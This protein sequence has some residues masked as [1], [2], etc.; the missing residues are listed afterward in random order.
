MAP[1]LLEQ[2]AVHALQQR[3]WADAHALAIRLIEQSGLEPSGHF[4]AGVAALESKK[5][6]EAQAHLEQA[7]ALA[8]HRPDI[9][10][11]LARAR[12]SSQHY[13]SALEAA[14]QAAA[15]LSQGSPG[16]FDTLGVVLVQCHAY[17]RAADAFKQAA[18][19]APEDAAVRFNLGTALTFLGDLDGA[20]LEFEAS[21]SFNPHLW[22]AHHSLSQ[23]RRQTARSNHVSRLSALLEHA[24]ATV[25]ARSFL[26]MAMSKELDDLG[27]H[28]AAFD[29]CVAGKNAP[30]QMLGYSRARQEDLFAAL[31]ASFPAPFSE[32]TTSGAAADDP[33]FVVGMPRSGTTLVDR[34]ISSHSDVQ[35]AGELHN[36]PSAWKRALGGASFEMFNP[37]HISR[38]SDREID[39]RALGE[40]YV[41]STRAFTGSR[42]FFTDKLPHNFLY[43]GYIACALPRAK[44]VCVRRNPLDTCLANFR[45]LFGPE[46]PYFDYSYDLLD[47]GHYFIL[48]DRL[49]SHWKEVFPG[50]ILEV[51][52]ETLVQ[53]QEQSSRAL[54]S[55]CEID[56]EDACLTFEKNT[57]PVTTA[58]AVQVRAPMYATALGRWKRYR[59]RLQPLKEMLEHAGLDCD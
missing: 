45:Q 5:V 6:V 12:A 51:Q 34:I 36:F 1:N 39:W 56:W 21:I 10:L 42:R 4:I 32:S 15:L 33:I 27:E 55:H 25:T 13:I 8:S 52:Y 18:R 3:R 50:R 7:V 46:S 31:A 58:S 37:A 26:H 48:F 30:K 49:M 59:H 47:T 53:A 22:R 35:S 29:H 14:D 11:L 40:A 17:E 43:L 20:E 19:L 38:A 41:A 28:D 23:L 16:D 24:P 44:L 54:I 9:W 57:S 2:D